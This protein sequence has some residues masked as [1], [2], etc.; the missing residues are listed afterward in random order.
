MADLARPLMIPEEESPDGTT[1]ER[2]Q[3]SRRRRREL[4]HET[5][6]PSISPLTLAGVWMQKKENLDRFFLDIYRYYEER[7]F[8]NCCL[9]GGFDLM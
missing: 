4:F 9:K 8:L 7:G 3:T 6:T 5:D 2:L 1:R